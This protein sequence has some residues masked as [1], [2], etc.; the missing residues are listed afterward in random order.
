M[1]LLSSSKEK[2]RSNRLRLTFKK[3]DC[4]VFCHGN[5]GNR[6]SIFECLEFILKRNFVAVSFD[7][8]GYFGIFLEIRSGNSNGNYVTLGFK[9]KFDLKCVIQNLRE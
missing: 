9:E 7:F 2:T 4:V 8:S 6:S 5:S 1:L 3:Y